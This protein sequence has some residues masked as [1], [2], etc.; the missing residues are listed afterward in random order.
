MFSLSL[1]ARRGEGV[2]E[3]LLR[4]NPTLRVSSGTGHFAGSK[5]TGESQSV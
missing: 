3:M 5:N 2:K 1:P 4:K